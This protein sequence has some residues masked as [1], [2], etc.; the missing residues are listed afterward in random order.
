VAPCQG[1]G[2]TMYSEPLK[3]DRHG[4]YAGIPFYRSEP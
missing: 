4:R 2:R 3:P 1:Q